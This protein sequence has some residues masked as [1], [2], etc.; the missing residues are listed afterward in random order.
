MGKGDRSGKM[1]RR[2]RQAKKKARQQ[3]KLPKAKR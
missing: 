1:R 3:A 2:D